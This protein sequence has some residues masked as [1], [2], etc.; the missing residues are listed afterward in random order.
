MF[1][2]LFT[3]TN[4]SNLLYFCTLF[5]SKI[6]KYSAS[7]WNIQIN[8]FILLCLR[9]IIIKKK[10]A[11]P[12]F[13]WMTTLSLTRYWLCENWTNVILFLKQ[14]QLSVCTLNLGPRDSTNL[15]KYKL[16]NL[17][18]LRPIMQTSANKKW[19][20][21]KMRRKTLHYITMEAFYKIVNT[22]SLR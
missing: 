17:I 8:K 6:I 21:K 3:W 14:R 13:T 9:T 10:T 7:D 18:L 16:I 1:A 22:N 5:K 4:I 2:L 20:Q 12:I 11:K 15:T 19:L